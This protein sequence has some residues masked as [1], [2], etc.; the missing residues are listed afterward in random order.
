MIRTI[1]NRVSLPFEEVRQKTDEDGMEYSQIEGYMVKY[2]MRSSIM[3]D[4]WG[5]KFV[6]R[7]SNGAFTESLGERNQKALWN[8]DW[9]KPL[10]SVMAGTLGFMDSSDGLRYMID[11][12]GNSWGKDATVSISRGDTNGASFTFKVQE[13]IWDIIEVD[14]E[15]IY[16]RTVL[17]AKLYEVSPCTMP[18]YPDSTAEARSL[19]CRELCKDDKME[20][21][22]L[23]LLIETM[24]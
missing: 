11:V 4:Y 21:R 16:Q 23:K 1:E 10:G 20:A 6:E 12:P 17:K 19:K 8:H 18:A 24:L 13:D 14:G 15:E 2:N 7:F 9:S 22:K 5:D 3:Y